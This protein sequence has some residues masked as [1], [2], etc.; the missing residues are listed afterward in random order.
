MARSSLNAV[1]EEL[2]AFNIWVAGMLA[3]SNKTQRD[4]A[5][6]L[7]MTQPSISYRLSGQVQWSLRDFFKIQEFFN[8]KYKEKS[9]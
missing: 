5:D 9:I 1:G 3:V 4:L 6:Y 8:E 7:C 2:K